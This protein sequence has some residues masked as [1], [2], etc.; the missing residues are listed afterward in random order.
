MSSSKT[1]SKWKG[2]NK[3]INNY[4]FK[5]EKY[6]NRSFI[7]EDIPI[8]IKHIKYSISL[9]IGDMGIKIT[10]RYHYITPRMTKITKTD[11]T[12]KWKC[13]AHSNKKWYEHYGKQRAIS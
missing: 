7:K 6:L 1:L 8:F 13:R 5:W 9:V 12:N 10:M 4:T 2:N 11:N 3:K